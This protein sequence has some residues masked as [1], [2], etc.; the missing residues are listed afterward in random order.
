[1]PMFNPFSLD[2]PYDANQFWDNLGAYNGNTG[3]DEMLDLVREIQTSDNYFSLLVAFPHETTVGALQTMNGS[4]QIPEGS[5]ITSISQYSDPN[6]NPEGF[7]LMLY[8]KGTKVSIFYGDYCKSNLVAGSM[9]VTQSNRPVGPNMLLSPFI[10]TRPGVLGWE[11]VNRSESDAILQVCLA[12]AVP[13][14]RRTT[15][16]VVVKK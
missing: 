15:N 2:A 4:V 12:V 8:D 9:L 6:T 16:Q 7:N 5:Y 11:I 1:M 13:V 14:N 10:I 3:V